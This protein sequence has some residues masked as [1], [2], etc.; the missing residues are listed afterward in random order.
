MTRVPQCDPKAN[1]LAHKPEIDAAVA[2][3][4]EGGRYILGQEVETFERDFAAYLGAGMPS[5]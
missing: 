4:L 3:V 5:A 2:R 1:Y